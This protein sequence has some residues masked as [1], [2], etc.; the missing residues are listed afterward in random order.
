VYELSTVL[1]QGH[2]LSNTRRLIKDNVVM[3]SVFF[4]STQKRIVFNPPV[5]KWFVV[6]NIPSDYL[7]VYLNQ[8]PFKKVKN[9]QQVLI[10]VTI[11]LRRIV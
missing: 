2:S 9:L 10:T 1:V 7:T 8:W 5:L 3:S 6:N 4:N 11:L